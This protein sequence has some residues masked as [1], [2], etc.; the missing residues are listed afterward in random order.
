MIFAKDGDINVDGIQ[1]V[2]LEEWCLL[3][4]SIFKSIFKDE[5]ADKMR[6]TVEFIIENSNEL[7]K[8]KG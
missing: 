1:E 7:D 8:M 3:S 5:Y 6:E 4:D 2:V